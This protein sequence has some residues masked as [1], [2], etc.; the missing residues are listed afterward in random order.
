MSTNDP[1]VVVETG[2]V[3]DL[4]SRL[5]LSKQAVRNIVDATLR[6]YSMLVQSD[7]TVS[8]WQPFSDAVTRL[9]VVMGDD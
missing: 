5:R 7:Y 8:S 2:T 1:V 9:Q 4:D 6:E 3:Y